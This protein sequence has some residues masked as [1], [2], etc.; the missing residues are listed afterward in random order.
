VIQRAWSALLVFKPLRC[1]CPKPNELRHYLKKRASFYSNSDYYPELWIQDD[2]HVYAG[3]RHRWRPLRGRDRIDPLTTLVGVI[4]NPTNKLR[5]YMVA[6]VID[7]GRKIPV[8]FGSYEGVKRGGLTKF[9]EVP[10][11]GVRPCCESACHPSV[12]T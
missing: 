2:N 6:A 11:S 12:P 10:R 1:R 9:T 3:G 7:R 8:A 5:K 4:D